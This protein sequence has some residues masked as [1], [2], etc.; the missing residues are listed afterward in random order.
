MVRDERHLLYVGIKNSV[1]AL[2]TRDGSERWRSK[3]GG[4]GYTN[5]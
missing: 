5:V 4:F 3:L 1:V 2:D